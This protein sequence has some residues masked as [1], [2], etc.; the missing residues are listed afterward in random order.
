MKFGSILAAVAAFATTAA[1]MAQVVPATAP[2]A[3]TSTFTLTD[4]KVTENVM[5][6]TFK[7]G[8]S[9]LVGLDTTLSLNLTKDIAVS[10]SA[11]VYTQGDHSSFG[12][13]NLGGSWDL[14]S[15]KN[16][17][18]GN[19]SLAL[20]G[21][22][23]IPMGAEFFR[24]QNVNPYIGADFGCMVWELNFNQT[25]QYRFDGGYA[26]IPVLG[27]QTDSDLMSFGSVLGYNWDKFEVGAKFDQY[28]YV[29]AGEAQL[30]LG[31]TAKWDIS[32]NVSVNGSVLV[33]VYQD[34]STP[35]ANVLIGAGLSIKF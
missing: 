9:T 18:L 34:V 19:W 24:S 14:F 3:S 6:N 21:G 11:P 15:G 35:E 27:A 4:W 30:F 28:Y 29:N 23:Y 5:F 8:G 12:D 13:L 26:Y 20:D 10:L 16:D 17:T 25:A 22:I 31:P 1:T 32:S 2:A 7:D 33:P